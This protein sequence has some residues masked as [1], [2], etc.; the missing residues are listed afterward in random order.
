MTFEN[1]EL[2]QD[3]D[4]R[5]ERVPDGRGP[6]VIA[7]G[8]G[9]A[10][11]AGVVWAAL[12]MLTQREIGFAAWG[13]GIA[14]GFAMSRVALRRSRA[15]AYTAAGFAVLGLLVGRVVIFAGSAGQVARELESD[16]TV[17]GGVVSWQMYDARELDQPTLEAIDAVNAANDTVSD[18]LWAAMR[19]QGTARLAGMTPAAKHGLAMTVARNLMHTMGIVGG[20]KAQLSAFDLLWLFLAV[21]TA[22]RLVAPAKPSPAPA[23][24]GGP[25]PAGQPGEDPP[26]S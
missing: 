10:L 15:M 24:E 21:G 9:A 1:E 17:L 6:L 4:G 8:L 14:V 3:L 19:Q 5:D 18:A 12:A 16:P 13:V 7:A 20:I 22:F 2:S 23:T 25:A 11:V 26:E